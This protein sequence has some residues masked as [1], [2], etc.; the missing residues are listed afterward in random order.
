MIGH[1]DE[2][3]GKRYSS[4]SLAEMKD[5]SSKVVALVQRGRI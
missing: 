3:S 4:V 2:A 5:A 1:A